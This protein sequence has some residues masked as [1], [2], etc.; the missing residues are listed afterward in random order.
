MFTLKATQDHLRFGGLVATLISL[1]AVRQDRCVHPA[2]HREI[3]GPN[4]ISEATTP[5]RSGVHVRFSEIKT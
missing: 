3:L 2:R 5:P 1:G 4:E